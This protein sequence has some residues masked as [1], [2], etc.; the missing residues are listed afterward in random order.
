MSWILPSIRWP[1]STRTGKR[2]SK[3]IA[4]KHLTLERL[5]ARKLFTVRMSNEDQ[6]LLELVNRARADPIA[7]IQ[8]NLILDRRDS[9]LTESDLVTDINQDLTENEEISADP[10]QP[11][12][13][14][15]A[16]ATAMEKHV[17]DML[18][19]DY[20]GHDSPEGSTPSSRARAEG[21]PTG[22]GENIA[23]SG[24]TDGIQQVEEIYKRHRGLVRSKGHR[25]NMMRDRWREVGSAVEYGTF[26]RDFQSF[27][28]IMVG[29]LF[30]NRG[31]NHFITGVAISDQVVRNN[32]YEIGEGLGGIRIEAKQIGTD[33]TYTTITGL[34]GGYSLRVPQGTYTLTASGSNI[35]RTIVRNI[36]VEDQNVKVDFNSAGMPTRYIA[37]HVYEDLNANRQR[38]D[39]DRDL[40]GQIVYIDLNDNAQHDVSE[41]SATTDETG[42]F[43]FSGL[44]P[45]E[46][47]I[48]QVLPKDWVHTQPVG[49][50]VVP[51][52]TQNLVGVDFGSLLFNETP[53]ANADSADVFSGRSV[54]I[55]VLSNDWDADGSLDFATLRV[56]RIPR[57]GIATVSS[58]NTLIYTPNADFSGVETF[59]YTV[60]DDRGGRSEP[61]LV[62][63]TVQPSLPFQNPDNPYDVNGDGFVVSR[64]VLIVVNELNRSGARSLSGF[65]RGPSIP[66]YDVSGDEFLSALDALRIIQHINQQTAAGEP[67]EIAATT[68]SAVEAATS[69]TATATAASTST[70]TST[71]S[72]TA[73]ASAS[74]SQDQLVADRDVFFAILAQS[75]NEED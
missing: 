73:S 16:L 63:V 28:S 27:R 60:D 52:S 41:L 50:Y 40:E 5:E 47:T 2:P 39:G 8:R 32:F 12:A 20:F 54:E 43:Q 58:S 51:L 14:H 21:Y 72:A 69:S 57:N 36:V 6:L 9:D 31:G 56:S 26:R 44:L 65:S 19:R 67:P 45:G 37:G 13:P 61:G 29:T 24:R 70:S 49:T 66:Y 71:A 42:R 10:K 23:W 3:R 7:E 64:D 34:S 15:Q 59:A 35:R 62:T 22:A 68:V 55:P 4:A 1:R 38:D 74:T 17:N 48:R 33:E 46:Y 25:V 11:L 18:L 53:V 30:G 75:D